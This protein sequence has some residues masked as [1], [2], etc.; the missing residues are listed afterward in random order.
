MSS[1]ILHSYRV[2][3]GAQEEQARAAT[4]Q[5]FEPGL[6]DPNM[7]EILFFGFLLA[8]HSGLSAG[9]L[10]RWATQVV[11][12]RPR[13]QELGAAW[14][15]LTE[16]D[17][18]NGFAKE[19]PRSELWEP[20]KK[21]LVEHSWSKPELGKIADAMSTWNGEGCY[22]GLNHEHLY[23]Y[24]NKSKPK[25]GLRP[26]KKDPAPPRWRT[27][28][29]VLVADLVKRHLTEMRRVL[30]LDAPEDEIVTPL[31]RTQRAEVE[32]ERLT[33]ENARLREERDKA[34]NAYRKASNRNADSA[35]ARRKAVKAAKSAVQEAAEKKLQERE[36]APPFDVALVGKQL[37]IC[38]P[39]KLN[40][41]TAKIWA[42]GKVLRIADGLTDT[43]SARA[44]KVLPAGA[45]L[46]AWDADPE[47]NEQA[48]QEWLFLRPERWNRHV[49]YAWRYD[50][51][52]LVPQ[53]AARPPA[54]APRMDA[55]EPWLTDEEYDPVDDFE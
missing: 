20:V 24:F 25:L 27:W 13:A 30:N 42:S 15:P 7:T 8:Q 52:E 33:V 31:E 19:G 47:Y 32:S 40:G 55:E 17:G 29:I 37:E 2:S 23:Q 12:D 4:C 10:R 28:S 54:R 48:G 43:K 34:Q 53:G 36:V 50:P 16:N 5:W 9:D 11:A 51:C 14:K 21:A 22:G 18:E 38:W 41:K 46:W 1:D 44:R 45:V 49:Q 39:Y 6:A 35:K 3:A 26:N